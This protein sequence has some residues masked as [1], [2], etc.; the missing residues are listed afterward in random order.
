MGSQ[1]AMPRGVWI[2][3]HARSNRSQ[4]TAY[5]GFRPQACHRG[6]NILRASPEEEMPSSPSY[7]LQST[8]TTRPDGEARMGSVSGLM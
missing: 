8:A 7:V 1:Y 6:A 5:L 4:T 3:I 2:R